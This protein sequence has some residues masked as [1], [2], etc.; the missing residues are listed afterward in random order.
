MPLFSPRLI[1]IHV[2]CASLLKVLH[3]IQVEGGVQ[4]MR[5][6]DLGDNIVEIRHS[7]GS[8]RWLV[9]KKMLDASKISLQAKSGVDVES[10][11]IALA[12]PMKPSAQ[13]TLSQVCE[14]F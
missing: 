7:D 1:Y 4:R 11:E 9:I 2:I 3:L 10:T 5:R 6:Y 13:R 14:P 8:D 12:F